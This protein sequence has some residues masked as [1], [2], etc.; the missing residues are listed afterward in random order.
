MY[1]FSLPKAKHYKG[2]L[3]YGGKLKKWLDFKF[4]SSY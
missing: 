3:V 4:D 1:L 2:G